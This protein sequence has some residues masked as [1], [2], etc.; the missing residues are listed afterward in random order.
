[1]GGREERI[2]WVGRKR[3]GLHWR[4]VGLVGGK[5]EGCI[6]G[7]EGRG[8][9][10]REVGLVGRKRRGL[11]WWE[12]KRIELEGRKRIEWVGDIITPKDNTCIWWKHRREGK[13]RGGGREEGEDTKG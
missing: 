10:W 3:R 5:E 13:E 11:N 7:R 4:E 6:G 12:E 9:N 1:M 8:L 2:E